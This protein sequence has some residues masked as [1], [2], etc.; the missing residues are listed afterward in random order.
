LEQYAQDMIALSGD[1]TSE[2]AQHVVSGK[3]DTFLLERISF[4]QKIF[5]KENYFLEI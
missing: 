1:L 5:G 4:Y 2:L 3:D